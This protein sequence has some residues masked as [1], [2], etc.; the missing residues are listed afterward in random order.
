VDASDLALRN[1]TT[2]SS[3]SSAARRL[4]RRSLLFRSEEH[5]V[6]WLGDRSPGATSP[7]TKLAELAVAWMHDRLAPD[8]RP[9]TRE[10]NQASSKGSA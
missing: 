3:S 4:R 10:Q 5:I 7:V 1:L 2:R 8:W 6:R 9:H